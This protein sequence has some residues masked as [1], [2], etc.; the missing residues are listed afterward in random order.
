[1]AADMLAIEAIEEAGPPEKAPAQMP[2]THSIQPRLA[3]L[4]HPLSHPWNA[5]L[6]PGVLC[7]AHHTRST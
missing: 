5:Q 6:H 1:M 7:R 2:I 3:N 4:Y